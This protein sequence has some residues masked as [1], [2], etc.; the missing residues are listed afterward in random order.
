VKRY[1]LRC[2]ACGHVNPFSLRRIFC[3]RCGDLLEVKVEAD[4]VFDRERLIGRVNSMW[5]YAEL[6]PDFGRPVTMGEGMTRL[7]RCERLARSWASWSS[8]SS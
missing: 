4:E 2:I 8:T 3:E 5:R 1:E 6:L 7:V